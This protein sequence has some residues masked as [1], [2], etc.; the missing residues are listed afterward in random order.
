MDISGPSAVARDTPSRWAMDWQQIPRSHTEVERSHTCAASRTHIVH[1][2][3]RSIRQRHEVI[4]TA[5]RWQISIAWSGVSK[6]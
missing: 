3:G 2:A 6:A 1:V 5:S 4:N